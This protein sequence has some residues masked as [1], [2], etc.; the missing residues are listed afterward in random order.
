MCIPCSP[1]SWYTKISSCR[2]NNTLSLHPQLH[3]KMFIFNSTY[4]QVFLAVSWEVLYIRN[5]MYIFYTNRFP[6]TE[7]QILLPLDSHT[8][9]SFQSQRLAFVHHLT[10]CPTRYQT[11]KLQIMDTT[12]CLHHVVLVSYGRKLSGEKTFAFFAVSESSAKVFSVNFVGGDH[13]YGRTSNPRK[14]FFCEMLVC[15]RIA[16][17]FSL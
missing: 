17:V 9:G 7:L 3:T 4:Q 6:H 8:G 16:K 11:E 14:L 10:L 15:H 12:V 13:L 2:D 5:I 1:S